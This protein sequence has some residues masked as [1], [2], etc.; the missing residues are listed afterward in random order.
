MLEEGLELRGYAVRSA[1]NPPE[2]LELLRRRKADL[3]IADPAPSEG[4]DGRVLDDIH[5]EFPYIPSILISD[6][7]FDPASLSPVLPG[8]GDGQGQRRL[9]RRPFTL[10]ELLDLAD[11]L[12]P[13]RQGDAASH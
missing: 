4:H 13:D 8:E 12:L 6:G 9:L 11:R 2:A 10:G 5:K 1:T 3:V 7:T